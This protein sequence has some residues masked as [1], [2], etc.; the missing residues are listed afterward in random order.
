MDKEPP[1]D[2]GTR[3]H[4][5]SQH[6][7]KTSATVVKHAEAARQAVARIEEAERSTP[8]SPVRPPRPAG[9]TPTKAS[10]GSA[11]T[12]S[13]PA[14][15]RDV[16]L[17]PL[18]IAPP[19]TRQQQHAPPP[20]SP[21]GPRPPLSPRAQTDLGTGSAI[22]P[23]IIFQEP[24]PNHRHVSDPVNRLP[25]NVDSSSASSSTTSHDPY[26]MSSQHG[27]HSY[28]QQHHLSLPLASS[29]P[30]SPSPISVPN[31][32]NEEL[33]LFLHDIAQRIN[34][35]QAGDRSSLLSNSSYG[36]TS[37]AASAVSTSQ[38]L[39]QPS[40]RTST[41]ATTG[42]TPGSAPITPMTPM[43][44]AFSSI[45]SPALPSDDQFE[46]AENDNSDVCSVHSNAHTY[47]SRHNSGG[48]WMDAGSDHGS[49]IGLGIGGAGGNAFP[50]SSFRGPGRETLLPPGARPAPSPHKNAR[51]SVASSVASS[52]TGKSQ[53]PPYQSSQAQQQP[54]HAPYRTPSAGSSYGAHD[55]EKENGMGPDSRRGSASSHHSSSY[56]SHVRH[57]IERTPT[58]PHPTRPAPPAPVA[59]SA[60]ALPSPPPA[61]Y[62][63]GSAQSG[64]S[65]SSSA[66][67]SPRPPLGET[68]RATS[69]GNNSPTFALT[70]PV[71]TSRTRKPVPLDLT[72]GLD[73]TSGHNH[74]RYPSSPNTPFTP[75]SAASTFGLQTP[76]TTS[77]FHSHSSGSY[78]SGKSSSG[79]GGDKGNSSASWFHNLFSFKAPHYTLP[80]HPQARATARELLESLSVHVAGSH[81][82]H[83][84]S[85]LRCEFRGN[86]VQ[87]AVRFRCEFTSKSGGMTMVQEKGALSSFKWI[88]GILKREWAA[89]FPP[90]AESPMREGFVYVVSLR[91][92]VCLVFEG[93]ADLIVCSFSDLT[94]F[95]RSLGVVFA[96]LLSCSSLPC[97][98]DPPHFS[99]SSMSFSSDSRPVSTYLLIRHPSVSVLFLFILSVLCTCSAQRCPLSSSMCRVCLTLP[100]IHMV[101]RLLVSFIWRSLYGCTHISSLHKAS[102]YGRSRA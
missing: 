30:A 13:A 8:S 9:P 23:A 95:P 33:Q 59:S 101:S 21:V 7:R 2:K 55:S 80:Y 25:L 93:D 64:A 91:D 4:V 84:G 73:L 52:S 17:S 85:A 11:A 83:D 78:H 82:P 71:K 49:A 48:S 16:Q 27:G 76:T 58:K 98:P 41:V 20:R 97:P 81:H 102:I 68:I 10:A 46:D 62:R 65:A 57:S 42:A 19:T 79:G 31:V 53:Q 44:P 54:P 39:Q 50:P 34:G 5:V 18:R 96:C 56:P 47:D 12:V 70:V 43:T 15:V 45:H 69:T 86:A 63:T 61:A 100:F 92:S 14:A 40:F 72:Q 99:F 3:R 22:V 24:S 75:F 66:S 89:S 90:E 26:G 36:A 6:R 94:P 38:Y 29:A 37:P 51:W 28:H 60:S 67:T 77:T 35:A 87:K 32:E 88:H 74:D 1:P